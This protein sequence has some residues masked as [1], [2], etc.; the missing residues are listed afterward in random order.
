MK[1]PLILATLGATILLQATL[2][3]AQTGGNSAALMQIEIGQLQL[4]NKLNSSSCELSA[5]ARSA[6][7]KAAYGGFASRPVPAAEFEKDLKDA[8]ACAER[9]L[10]ALEKVNQRAREG[11]PSCRSFHAKL[12]DVQSWA[13]DNFLEHH[14]PQT[15][16]EEA[17]RQRAASYRSQYDGLLNSIKA[18]RAFTC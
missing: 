7:Y 17:A 1:K 9:A 5:V 10:A 14:T 11:L 3:S 2:P 4:T 15:N 12:R 16:G 18:D 6:W 13:T 8:K